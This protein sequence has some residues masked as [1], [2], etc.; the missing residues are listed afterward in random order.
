MRRFRHTYGPWALI[1]GASAGLGTE[2]A[3]QLASQ[4]LNLVLVARRGNRLQALAQDLQQTY[5]IDTRVVPLDLAQASFLP[6]LTQATEGLD[7][8]LLINNA[9]SAVHNHFL[10]NDLN[11]ELQISNLNTRAPLILAHHFGQ[12]LQQRRRG[13]IIF[14]SSVVGL[15]GSPHWSNYAATKGHNLLLAEGLSAE[16]KPSGVDV[17]A[18]TPGFMSTD[19]M[20]LSAFGKLLAVKPKVVARVALNKLGK[21]PVVTPGFRHQLFAWSTRFLPRWL[22]TQIFARVVAGAHKVHKVQSLPARQRL[23]AAKG[24]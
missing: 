5:G 13:G 18:V 8:G 17:L 11:T 16:L 21:Q 9:G 2:F 23:S 12:H 20:P 15:V 3:R 22:N 1:T 14:L 7:I 10:A 24:Q 4:G 6:Q 19:L